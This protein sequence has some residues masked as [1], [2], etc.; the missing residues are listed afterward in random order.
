MVGIGVP[1][2]LVEVLL[3]PGVPQRLEER[4]L[5]QTTTLSVGARHQG[6]IAH[7]VHPAEIGTYACGRDGLSGDQTESQPRPDQGDP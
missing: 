3:G 4:S 6:N 1:Q 7:L 2:V 5:S